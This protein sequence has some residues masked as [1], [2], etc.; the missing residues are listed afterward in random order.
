MVILAASPQYCGYQPISL[1]RAIPNDSLASMAHSQTWPLS[2]TAN[3]P[4]GSC[5]VCHAVRQIHLKDGTV[6]RHGPRDKPCSG[7]NKPPIS[8]II[9]SVNVSSET[10][11]TPDVSLSHSGHSSQPQ[12]LS[13]SASQIGHP[14][15]SAPIVK[16]IPRSARPGCAKHLSTLLSNVVSGLDRVDTWNCLLNFGRD[17]LS[18]PRRTGKRHN[19]AAAI[20]KRITASEDDAPPVHAET[21]R[22]GTSNRNPND[23]LLAAVTSKIEDGNLRAAARL[24]CSDD[25]PAPPTAETLDRLQAKHPG[26]HYERSPF[27][28][29]Q[30]TSALVVSEEDVLKAIRSF[31]AGSA[32]GP[33]G[34]RPQHILDLVNNQEAGP[35]LLS[36]IT[37]FTNLLLEGRCHSQ[38]VPVLFGGNLIAL[39]K[40]SGDVRP[41]AVGYTWR[42]I[43]A[44][45][46]NTFALSKL[47]DYFNPLQLGVGIPGGCEAAVHSTRRFIE[48]MQADDVVVKLDFRNAFNCLHRD[49]MLKAVFEKVPELYRYCHQC[50]SQSSVLKFDHYSIYSHEGPQQGDPLGPL[51][52]CLSIHPLLDSLS[53]DLRIAFLDDLTLGG[54][55]PVVACDID[56]VRHGGEAIGLHLHPEKCEVISLNPSHHSKYFSSFQTVNP[57][58]AILLG[59]PLLPGASMEACLADC[60]SDLSRAIERLRLIGSHDALVMLRACFGAP[61][62]THILRCSPCHGQDALSVF[63]DLIK[64]GISTI[65]NSEISDMQFLQASL[66]VR[67]GGLGIRRASSLALSAFLA[68]AAAT[69]D[70]QSS[71]LADCGVISCDPHVA[72]MRL[73]WCSLSSA[74]C[75]VGTFASKQRSWD[76]PLVSVSKS[77][78]LHSVSDAHNKAR[79]IAVSSAHSGDWLHALPISACGLR[80]DNEAI[81]IAVGLRLGI[82]LCVPHVCPCGSLVDARG[83]HGL[84]CKH[85]AGKH[86]RHHQLNDIIWR[87]LARAGIPSVKEPTGLYRSDGKRPDGISQIPWE[88]GRCI[89]WDVTVIDTL[90]DSY[91]H[92][93]SK[94]AGSAAEL[95]SD[96]KDLKYTGLSSSFQFIPL[97]FETMGPMNKEAITFISELGR[98]TSKST[99]EPRETAFLFQRLS[100]LIQRFNAVSF[101]N[102]FAP[103][104]ADTQ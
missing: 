15:V 62:I 63:D 79:L 50:Y 34:I 61:K 67:D 11:I 70:L 97:A 26:V 30:V 78:L 95:A 100:V 31:P 29:P 57:D 22:V 8:E 98:R 3:K 73:V 56:S 82:K 90:A 69:S 77:L 99:G 39:E 44:K 18:Q 92:L 80:L 16:H 4:S 87:S 89:A 94:A 2:Q 21:H 47:T 32:G 102:S 68:S 35:D 25:K 84:A 45:C 75:P 36:S 42:R 48:G 51:L 12:H 76:E 54:K 81:R 66:P 55:A 74:D 60:C 86:T 5:S 41:I 96:R 52:F 23:I 10:A 38:V 13:M 71:I 1:S 20:R 28:D 9:N 33:D 64:S 88:H 6:H 93:T 104:D 17:I 19:L 7:S 101:A 24:L 49:T 65:C 58:E 72:D 91:L 53:S 27:A 83:T 85:N 59:A 40:R 43:A 14:S 103:T 37:L 46:A